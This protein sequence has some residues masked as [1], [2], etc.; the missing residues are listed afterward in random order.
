[1]G[2]GGR[3]GPCRS[4]PFGGHDVEKRPKGTGD[5]VVEAG[6][7]LTFRYRFV[8]HEGDAETAKIAAK[9]ETFADE[10]EKTD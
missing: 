1:M 5:L 4:Q 9:Y 2:P 10:T 8:F 3:R 6:K 7:E